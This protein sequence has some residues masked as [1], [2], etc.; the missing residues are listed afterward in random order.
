M[1]PPSS[2]IR[3]NNDFLRYIENSPETPEIAE[4][5]RLKA[6]RLKLETER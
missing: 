2:L 4:I 5:K 1:S 6:E 3:S